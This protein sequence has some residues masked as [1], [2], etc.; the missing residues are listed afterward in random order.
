[1][2]PRQLETLLKLKPPI[3]CIDDTFNT[4]KWKVSRG[5]WFAACHWRFRN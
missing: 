1:M 2:T 4:T 5:L 3:V